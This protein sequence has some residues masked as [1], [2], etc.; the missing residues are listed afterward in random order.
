MNTFLQDLKYGLRMLA[1]NP[2]FTAV[3]VITL[4]LGIGANTAIFSVVNGVLLRPL[5]YPRPDGIV[6]LLLQWKGGGTN[7]TLTAPEFEFY[8]D[9]NDVFQAVAGFRGSG[10]LNLKQG[11]SYEWL[12]ALQVTDGFFS[13]LGVSPALGRGFTRDETRPGTANA[14]VLSDGLWRKAFN[15]DPHIVGEQVELNAESC[16]VVGVMARGFTFVEQPVDVFTSLKLGHTLADTGMNTTVLAR[17]KP[18]ITLE[19]TQAGMAV[20]FEQF[21]KAGLAQGGQQGVKLEGYQHWLLGDFRP[22]LLILFGAVGLLLLIACANVAGFFLARATARQREISIRLA[23]GAGRGRLW[24]QLLT[25]GLLMA[26]AGGAAGLMGAVWS[27]NGLVSSV[28]WDLPAGTE[29]KL[30]GRVLVFTFVVAVGTSIV[31][32]LASFWQASKLDLNSSLKESSRQIGGARSRLRS[33]LVVGEVALSLM[34]LVGTGLLIES[35]YHLRE[36]K[37]G[38]D[39][40]H[41]VTMETP[42]SPAK[43][44]TTAQLWNFEQEVLGRFEALPGV[45]S[46]AVVSVPPLLGQWNLPTQHE[47]HPDDSIGGMEYRAISPQYFT[48][49]RIPILAGRR[50]LDSDTASSTPVVVI[51]ETVARR[52]WGAKSPIGDRLVVGEYHGRHFPEVEEPAREV[53]GVAGDVKGMTLDAPAPPMLYVPAPQVSNAIHSSTWWVVRTEGDVDLGGALRRAIAQVNP[54]QRVTSVESMTD[55]VARS[56]ARPNFDAL[57]MGLFAILALALTSVGIYGVLNSYV[58][59]RTHEIGVRMALGAAATDVLKTV[60]RQGAILAAVGI[61]VGLVSALSLTRLMASLLYGVRPTDP[62]TFLVV[63]LLLAGVAVL[64]SYLP[65]RRATKVDPMVALRYE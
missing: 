64:A 36:E 33:A 25:E 34:L 3:A 5:P 11:N 39:P 45:S 16:T 10:D 47:G 26:L 58:T 20:V 52:W 4:A 49:T 13:A 37:L 35:L 2:G 7:D 19:Q 27:L 43:D 56:V 41:L 50:I 60:V 42:F 55:V 46:A 40:H 21:R 57:L 53:V 30:D 17:L 32:G 63:S 6:R 65:A 54:E 59:Q 1:K 48:A 44:W 12:S 38:F 14:V 62:A 31:L 8:R 29:I 15:A 18:G 24:R 23:L 61:G 28:P 9:H 22:S 51:N